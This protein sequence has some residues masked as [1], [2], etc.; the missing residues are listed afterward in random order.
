VWDSFLLYG[1]RI[2]SF[3]AASFLMA[4]PHF[5][6]QSWQWKADKMVMP[7]GILK[8]LLALLLL[9]LWSTFWLALMIRLAADEVE[10]RAEGLGG[11]VGQ[12]SVAMVVWMI[13][14]E[15]L[16]SLATGLATLLFIIPGIIVAVR[17]SLTAPVIVCEGLGPV[18]A[19]RRSGRLVKGHG[20]SVFGA[21]ILLACISLVCVFL[22][23][24]VLWASEGFST[25]TRSFFKIWVM[26]INMPTQAILSPF[27]AIVP[28]LFYI[29]LRL[30]LD[31]ASEQP[32][33]S[34]LPETVP[35]DGSRSENG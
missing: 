34:G 27:T 6:F 22:V 32:I 35:P 33:L 16:V 7:P 1:R 11:A 12:L 23:G 25:T 31:A 17:L 14:A 4:L 29:P 18:K 24:T 28:T 5:L 20:W 10:D 13:I 26:G 15:L 8:P 9:A 30:K 2:P 21:F 19:M 3:L